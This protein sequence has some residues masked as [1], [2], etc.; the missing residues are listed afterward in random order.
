MSLNKLFPALLLIGGMVLMQIHAIQ[1]WTEH[2]G[3]YGALWSVLIE[4]AALW[5]WSQRNALKNALAVVATLL[6]LTGPLYQV[7]APAV[8]Q[9][10]S[11]QTNTQ[12]QQL[13]AA[14]IASLESSLAQYNSNSGTRVGW[15]ARIDAT[16]AALNAKRTE[17]SQLIT[18]PS[19]TPWQT[20]AIVLMQALAL[21]LIQI[22][23]VLAIRA[24][25]EKPVSQWAENAMQAPPLKRELKAVKTAKPKAPV[26]RQ[27]AAA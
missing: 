19:A 15:A 17:L 1:F 27:A 25:S 22:V 2:T 6:A 23:I 9:L 12:Q 20:I 18:A 4:G 8:E 14:E 16:Q 5:L 3:Q 13:I 26:M 21:L 11:T 10:R 7:A 24:V